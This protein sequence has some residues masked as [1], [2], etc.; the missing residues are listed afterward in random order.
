MQEA[1]NISQSTPTVDELKTSILPA[2]FADTGAIS[3]YGAAPSGAKAIDEISN[4]MEGGS[5]G[6]LAQRIG[7]IIAKLSDADPQRIARPASWLERLTGRHIERQVR[8]QVA[9]QGLDELIAET[10][11]IA[12]R[13]RDTLK[14]LD[15]LIAAH[16]TEAAN[17]KIYIQAGREY[18]EDN[19][20]AGVAEPGTVEFERP[21]DRFARKVANLATL[22]ASLEMSASQMKLTRAQAVDMLDRFSETATVLVPVWRRH[23]LALIQTKNTNPAIVAEAT[24]A[25]QALMRSLAKSLDGMEQ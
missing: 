13:V 12:Q 1:T 7:E 22:L 3:D 2:L 17:L 24:K 20:S 8:Y 11:V 25:H 10:E 6:A 14:S 21:R 18:L 23:T 9:R 5:V 15:R 19:P 16:S 4:L